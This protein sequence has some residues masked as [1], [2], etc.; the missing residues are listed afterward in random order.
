MLKYF[1]SLLVACHTTFGS[2]W[3]PSLQGD[4]A[5]LAVFIQTTSR[6][7]LSLKLDIWSSQ[8]LLNVALRLGAILLRVS[9]PSPCAHLLPSA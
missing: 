9:L 6:Q 7:S 8:H 4:K 3:A 1:I 2:I 5:P